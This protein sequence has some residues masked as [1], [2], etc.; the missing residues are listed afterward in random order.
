MRCRLEGEEIRSLY[1]TGRSSRVPSD[2]VVAIFGVLEAIEAASAPADLKSLLSLRFS[3]RPSGQFE[4]GLP[5]DWRL[6]GR[7]VVE[8]GVPLMIIED[9]RALEKGGLS[10]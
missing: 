1:A 9:I 4:F 2:V 3:N 10:D 6:V 5:S 7:R 8:A